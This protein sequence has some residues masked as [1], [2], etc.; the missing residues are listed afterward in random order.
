[1]DLTPL[2]CLVRSIPATFWGV[3]AGSLFTLIG[4]WLTNRAQWQRQERLL[5]H[6]RS[7]KSQERELSL[8]RDIYLAAADSVAAGFEAVMKRPN[9]S[10][11]HDKVFEAWSSKANA[12]TRTAVVAS[13]DSLRTLS[14]F[15]TAMS[16]RI[17][18]LFGTRI[19]VKLKAAKRDST[20]AEITRLNAANDRL[21]AMLPQ[22]D[23]AS[24]AGRARRETM[25][26]DFEASQTEVRALL[27]DHDR[28]NSEVFDDQLK[29]MQACTQ[30]SA[31]LG[32]LLIPVMVSVRPEM[33][34]PFDVE[35]YTAITR[36]SAAEAQSQIGTF[37]A[38]LRQLATDA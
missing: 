7:L 33:G 2:N 15:S 13:D 12:M 5:S 31:E 32:E 28:L 4:V 16:G 37:M 23:A 17:F 35:A 10:T 11:P 38:K 36:Q 14:A 6:E 18:A 29:L 26:A 20:M 21:V 22:V 34:L 8:K 3:L 24:D 27:L 1:M 19:D 25:L 30:A 9:I